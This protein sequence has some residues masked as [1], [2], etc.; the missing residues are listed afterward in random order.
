MKSYAIDKQDRRHRDA[1][2]A[3]HCDE[4]PSPPLAGPIPDFAH[5][6]TAREA[7]MSRAEYD[8]WR[9]CAYGCCTDEDCERCNERR[10]HVRA[11]AKAMGIMKQNGRVGT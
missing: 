6:V 10:R 1:V 7:G 3:A 9:R 2:W 5:D 11:A 4:H 8:K